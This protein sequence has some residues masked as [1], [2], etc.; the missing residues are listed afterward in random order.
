MNWLMI[1]V[2]LVGLNSH[3]ES[4]EYFKPLWSAAKK[5]F[6][7]AGAK[8][9]DQV[10]V[11][12][13]V[14]QMEGVSSLIKSTAQAQRNLFSIWKDG[15]GRLT[16]L[17]VEMDPN[18]MS[19]LSQRCD[20]CHFEI[21]HETPVVHCSDHCHKVGEEVIRTWQRARTLPKRKNET[22]FLSGKMNEI[23]G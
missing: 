19:V 23:S 18:N 9:E 22:R 8:G 20:C 2:I 14:D 1:A 15:Q 12:F 10:Y 4:G 5:E 21:L 11:V 16:T 17:Y 6:Y 13:A 3:A 7:K